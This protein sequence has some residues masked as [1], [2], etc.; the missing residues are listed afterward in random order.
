MLDAEIVR[1]LGF[2]S[3]PPMKHLFLDNFWRDT[4]KALETLRYSPEIIIEHM[5]P[6]IGKTEMDAGYAEVNSPEIGSHDQLAY[7]KYLSED[8]Q[9]DLDKLRK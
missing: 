3:P 8:F 9:N 6:Y 2:F 7:M 5:H 4:G 1:R